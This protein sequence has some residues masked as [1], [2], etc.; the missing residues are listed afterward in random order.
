M[1][2]T[3]DSVH[4]AVV[5]RYDINGDTLA[6][7]ECINPFYPDETFI[8]ASQV[9]TTLSNGD[10]I[11]ATGI[12]VGPESNTDIYFLRLDKDLNLIDTYIYADPLQNAPKD[13]IV[14]EEDDI[15]VGSVKSNIAQTSNNFTYRSHLLKLDETFDMEWQYITPAFE[16]Y[17]FANALLPT[18]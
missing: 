13:I 5:I 15:I 11:A 8:S 3:S 18:P 6:T 10:I 9:I 1:G 16:L 14:T 7:R 2:I 4:K 12:N 17:D